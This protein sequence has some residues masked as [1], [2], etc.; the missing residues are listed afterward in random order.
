M[1][2]SCL[3]QLVCYIRDPKDS[4]LRDSVHDTT[5]FTPTHFITICRHSRGGTNRT[6][7]A[8][9]CILIT[10]DKVSWRQLRH[11]FFF[12]TVFPWNN[13]SK[14]HMCLN[15]ISHSSVS[16]TALKRLPHL[17]PHPLI[18]INVEICFGFSKEAEDNQILKISYLP[19]RNCRSIY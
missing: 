12:Q 7:R 19:L 15:L 6:L 3:H 2:V 8:R 4:A 1:R 18:E 10:R 9:K 16:S 14:S 13:Y 11:F 17:Y 5:P